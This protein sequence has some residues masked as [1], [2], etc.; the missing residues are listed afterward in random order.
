MQSFECFRLSL[1]A[2]IH[3]ET[4]GF[5]TNIDLHPFNVYCFQKGQAKVEI[6]IPNPVVFVIQ[7]LA[8][9][10]YSDKNR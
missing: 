6:T 2:L 8:A 7:I 5:T 3:V 10:E 1:Y 4:S 9:P